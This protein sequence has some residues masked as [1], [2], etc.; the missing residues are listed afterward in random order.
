[1]D[2]LLRI[3]DLLKERNWSMYQLSKYSD[4]PQSTL[5]NLFIRYNTPSVPTLEKICDAFGITISEFF[6]EQ[7]LSKHSKEDALLLTEFH[8]LSADG[9]KAILTL[10]QEINKNK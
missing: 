5:S 4:I 8:K 1:M 2:C 6:N 7:P 3:Q 9:K 10:M